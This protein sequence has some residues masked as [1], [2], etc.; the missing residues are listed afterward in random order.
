VLHQLS[1]D[2]QVALAQQAQP[3]Q[4]ALK[5]TLETPDQLVHKEI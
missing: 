4:L 5:V 2:L 3:A 1:L